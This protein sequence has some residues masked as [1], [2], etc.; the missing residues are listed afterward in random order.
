MKVTRG[1]TDSN[2]DQIEGDWD[3]CRHGG[4]TDYLCHLC[5]SGRWR[6][7][8][9]EGGGL[10]DQGNNIK[11]ETDTEGKADIE[12]LEV[13]DEEEV[14]VEVREEVKEEVKEEGKEEVNEEVKVEDG[15]ELKVEKAGV[16]RGRAEEELRARLPPGIL[17]SRLPQGTSVARVA[18]PSTWPCPTCTFIN[19]SMATTCNM[20]SWAVAE[21]AGAGVTS[22]PTCTFYNAEEAAACS[23]CGA[24][25]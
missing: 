4:P 25:L 11:H 19:P 5:T 23:M 24:T 3:D 8:W 10:A 1:N 17:L 7:A 20:C 6:A 22:C 9:R 15:K 16:S 21:E 2:G 12:V 18:A 14:K 13:E